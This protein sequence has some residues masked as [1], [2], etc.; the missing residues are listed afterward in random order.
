MFNMWLLVGFVENWN[1]GFL[2]FGVRFGG[3]LFDDFYS[4]L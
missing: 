4:I 2:N 3:S 1:G